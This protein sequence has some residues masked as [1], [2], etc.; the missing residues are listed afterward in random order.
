MSLTAVETTRHLIDLLIMSCGLAVLVFSISRPKLRRRVFPTRG[1]SLLVV[2]TVMF[3]VTHWTQI[4]ATS[5]LASEFGV[6]ESG[7]LRAGIPDG[8][9]WLL[10]R[11][12]LVLIL[13]G[14]AMFIWSRKRLERTVS[15]TT[16]MIKVAQDSIARS[17]ARFRHLF[18]T[19]SNSIFCYVF[20]PPLPVSLPIAEQV[21]RSHD[22]VLTECN[23]VFARMLE[24]DE[25]AGVIGSRM[26]TLEANQDSKAHYEYFK[27]FIE[28]D[29][30][31]TDYELIYTTPDGED[32]AVRS[33]LTGI[34]RD[35]MLYRFWGAESNIL[36]IRRTQNALERRLR[37][38]EL[39]ATISS[40]LVTANAAD[41]DRVIERSMVELCRYVGADRTALIWYDT[42]SGEIELTHSYTAEGEQY[43]APITLSTFPQSAAQLQNNA[44]VRVD[45]AENPPAEVAADRQAFIARGL[46]SFVA[47]PLS[48][49]EK[50]VGVSTY[51]HTSGKRSWSDQEIVDLRVFAEL[52]ASFVMR[53]RSHRALDAALSG[54]R[55]ATE[56]LEAENVYLRE[57]VE[58]NHGFDEIIGQ[59]D[60]ILRCLNLVELVAD[61]QTPV[62]ILGETGT[63]KELIARAIHDHSS[64][65]DRPLVK[66][67]CAALPS[68]LIESELFGYE[69]GAFT[70]ADSAKRGRF[71]LAN[72]STLFLDEIGDFPIELQTKLLRALQEGEIERLGGSESIKVD[73]RIIAATNRDLSAAVRGGEFRSD[74]FYRINTFPIELPPL[75]DRGD[76]IQLLAEHFVNVHAK[77]LG[78][79]VSAISA[80]MMR[81]LREHH[82]PGNVRELDG[83]IQRALI[84]SSSPVLQL[85]DPLEVGTAR[86][87]DD[88]PQVLSTNIANLR[89]V[90]REHILSVLDET[91]WKIAGDAGAAARLG[92]PPSTLR[93]KMK[94]LS[95]FRP[96]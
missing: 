78:R 81:Q 6:P 69:K 22:A 52:F 64:R 9:F 89:I 5:F 26:G 65:R 29:Y 1:R 27:A 44:V 10:T 14:L 34:V 17:E 8:L 58:Q 47:L 19:T 21:R 2:G 24:A 74:L 57:E 12:A 63:G 90:E 16:D 35:G 61:T 85:A 87:S 68:N 66:V 94:K 55:R 25:P 51:V 84:S 88:L 37:Y 31:L 56:R 93:S 20:D 53:A 39:L 45:D 71:D 7:F 80:E 41:G 48:V 92:L 43:E 32:R 36:D 49:D 33:S 96:A 11:V 4:I 46:K 83:V 13:L 70:G 72:G 82:W 77:S 15:T 59:S 42:A 75:R 95:I 54:L 23:A 86:Q 38:Q 91:G 73:V 30:R 28:N 50:V 79:E 18:E 76:D 3:V 60:A 67:N 40:R 62:L